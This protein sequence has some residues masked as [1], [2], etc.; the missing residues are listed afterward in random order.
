MARDIVMWLAVALLLSCS[1]AIAASV[2]SL[3]EIGE[4]R[5]VEA[6][7]KNVFAKGTDND[8]DQ[9]VQVFAPDNSAEVE[10]LKAV[11]L[12]PQDFQALVLDPYN[13]SCTLADSEDYNTFSITNNKQIF[14]IGME[15]RFG[16][17][18][19]RSP[20]GLSLSLTIYLSILSRSLSCSFFLIFSLSLSLSIYIYI[21]IY[22]C[23]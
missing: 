11:E 19:L 14:T 23:I 10:A 21:Y 22:I 5:S 15:V 17:F 20:H 8:V 13:P 2:R 9:S 3:K 7:F 1:S 12:T 18:A 6:N 4:T 16:R